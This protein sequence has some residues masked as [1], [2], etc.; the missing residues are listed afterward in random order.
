MW[1]VST[2]QDTSGLPPGAT[3]G[4]NNDNRLTGSPLEQGAASVGVEQSGIL[5][6]TRRKTEEG[7]I[8]MPSSYDGRGQTTAGPSLRELE[9]SLR[10]FTRVFSAALWR[11]LS[12]PLGW[13]H[14]GDSDADSAGDSAW[15]CVYSA[16]R[17]VVWCDGGGFGWVVVALRPDRRL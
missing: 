17:T 16:A 9:T 7:T 5:D 11:L 6:P 3:F 15:R 4:R 10:F 14:R 12:A 13:R 2:E 8:E 1:A